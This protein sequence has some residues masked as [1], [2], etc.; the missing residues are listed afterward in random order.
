VKKIFLCCAILFYQHIVLNGQSEWVVYNSS[1][2]PLPSNHILNITIDPFNNKWIS[3][4]TGLLKIND[5]DFTDFS[6]WEIIP[7]PN[8]WIFAL[9][10]DNSGNIWF[11]GNGLI[12]YDGDNFT[13]YNTQNSGIPSNKIYSIIADFSNNIWIMCGWQPNIYLVKFD[14]NNSWQQFPEILLI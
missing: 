14:G 4:E 3:T 9:L 8:D 12:K 5:G 7:T 13:V 6:K 11:G 10:A 1:N 2:S